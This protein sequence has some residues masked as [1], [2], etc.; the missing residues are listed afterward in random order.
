MITQTLFRAVTPA[1]RTLSCAVILAAALAACLPAAADTIVDAEG[2]RVEVTD[3]SRIVSIGGAVTEILF[4]L[5]LADQVIAVDTTSTYPA[6]AQAKPDVGYMRALSS[7]GVLSL[8][9]SLILA[10]K[11]SGPKDVVD[12]LATASVP[13]V[14]IPDEP[15]AAGVGAKIRAVAAA[16]GVPEKGEEL[17]KAVEA[18]LK[19]VT[20]AVGKAG[21]QH[22]AAFVLSMANG[23]PLLA[24]DHTSAAGM[25]AL[26]GLRNAFA[27]DGFKPASPEAIVEAAPAIIVTM[28]RGG[29]DA[30]DA[31][32]QNPAFATT[33]AVKDGRIL[34]FDG[35]YLLNF[36]PRTAEAAREL[37]MTVYP[38]LAIPPLARHPWTET[39]AAAKP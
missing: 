16:A 30:T 39:A 3:R 23:A 10:V 2:R 25:F 18:D 34:A 38:E 37:A 31:I 8:G 29:H 14:M 22:S 26:A 28:G 5:G 9:P 13:M 4:A 24:G 11:G 19:T 33:P 1:R 17:A 35:A 27:F 21:A 7:E 6:A 20:D 12:V 36:G 32:R 15:T